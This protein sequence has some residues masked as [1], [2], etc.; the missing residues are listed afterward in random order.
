MKR[1][2]VIVH[3]TDFS[4]ASRRAFEAAVARAREA[5]ARLVLLHVLPGAI[6]PVGDGYI[7]DSTLRTIE[8]GQQR[9]AAKQ[10]D[11]LAVQA[12]RRGVRVAAE[13]RRGVAWQEIT[14]AADRLRAELVVLG[15]HGRSGLSRMFLGSVA[16]RVVGTSRRPVLTVHGGPARRRAS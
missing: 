9:E 6:V 7:P 12:R 2:R 1:T 11:K 15:T 10:L 13:V 5:H 8:A 3:P 14:R 16:E 4:P